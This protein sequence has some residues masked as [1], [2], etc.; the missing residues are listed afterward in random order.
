MCIAKNMHKTTIKEITPV[1]FNNF[2]TESK[3]LF[4]ILKTKKIMILFIKI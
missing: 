1:S 2:E 3:L 4:S